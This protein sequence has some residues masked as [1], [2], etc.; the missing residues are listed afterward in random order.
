[1]TRRPGRLKGMLG[2]VT[3]AVILLGS[4]LGILCSPGT[5]GTSGHD[6]QGG[7]IPGYTI[8]VGSYPFG[9]AFDM[10]SNLLYV[11]NPGSSNITVI[12]STRNVVAGSIPLASGIQ[13]IAVDTAT[14]HLY[15]AD[16]I[17]TVFD[18]DSTT[19][20]LAK[21]ISLLR[22]GCPSGCA[23]SV[24][25]YDQA[26]GDIYITDIATDNV[27][28]VHNGT[29][30]AS[31]PVGAFPNGAVYDP[32]NGYVY[33]VNEGSANLTVID[34]GDNKVVSQVTLVNP[35]PGMTYDPS[36][37]DLFV[38]SNSASASRPNTLTVVN[39]SK[40]KVVASVPIDSGCGG[41]VYDSYNDYVYIT[42]RYNLQGHDLSNVTVVD[43]NT[44]QIV[45]T[46]PVQQGPIGISY[47]S[48][49]HNIY[50]ADSDTNNVSVLPQV[51]RLIVRETG[52][53]PGTHWSATVGAATFFSTTSTISFP[54]TNGTFNFAIGP[55]A[56][57]SASPGSGSVAINGGPQWLNAT[58]TKG[59]GSGLFGLPG[60]TG[61][62]VF[63]GSVAVLVAA[64]VVVVVLTRRKRRAKPAPTTP[65]LDGAAGRDH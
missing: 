52:L 24:R 37:G 17:Y 46:L 2:S 63:G 40:N 3:T 10:V 48:M 30:V 14:G 43:P 58:F 45:L 57:L 4:S 56:N 47:D 64:T 61:Y 18:I 42:D 34:G 36:K 7:Y 5:P 60:E 39:G 19:N 26:N 20:T 33:V 16:G 38:C 28:V 62:Y 59:G 15:T 35:G 27:S 49:N 65:P 11:T 23:P 13:T 21:T 6:V 44:H 22:A 31:I 51:Y 54:E 8:S 32:A 29:V 53:P 12:N 1:M 25:T 41:A 50:V 9:I 55:A